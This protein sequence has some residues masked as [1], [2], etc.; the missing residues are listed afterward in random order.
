MEKVALVTGG[1]QGIGRGIAT[2]LSARGYRVAVADVKKTPAFPSFRCDVSSEAQVRLCIQKV[3]KT[4]GRLDALVNNAGL[5]GPANGPLEKLALKDWNRRIAVNL[6]G[7]FLMAKHC[8]PHLRR[9]RGA[10][11]NI[12]SIRALQSEP[13]TESYTASKAGLVGLTHAMAMTLGPRVRVNCISPGWIA[14]QSKLTKRAHAQH[15]AGRVGRDEDI[16]EMVAYL[17]S[18][19]AGFITGANFVIDGGMTRK[20]IYED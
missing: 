2:V 18:D 10:I 9:A 13:E 6:T 1:A 8:A 15:P 4:F 7:P 16:A 3:V 11:V 14:H 17:L 20:M 19:A 12:A 5:A